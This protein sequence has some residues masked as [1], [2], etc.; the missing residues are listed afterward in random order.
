MDISF[1]LPYLYGAFG[2]II[3]ALMGA[4]YH[5]IGNPDFSFSFL[6]FFKTVI[7][8]TVIGGFST[9]F[10]Q[11]VDVFGTSA[12]AASATAFVDRIF[13]MLIKKATS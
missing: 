4:G 7:I 10:G 13:N 11:P 6:N 8:G 2:G 9:Y 3:W 5:K 1:V 12:L